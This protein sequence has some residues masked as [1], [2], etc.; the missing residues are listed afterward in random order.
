[1]S[2]ADLDR[3]IATVRQLPE[4]AERAAPDVADVIE[5]ELMRTTTAGQSPNGTPWQ[6]TLEGGKPLTGAAKAIGVA[7]VGRTIYVRLTGVEARHHLG[8]ARGG[9]ERQ[10]IPTGRLPPR[11]ADAVREVLGRHFAELASGADHG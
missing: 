7:A 3:M 9:I 8:R 4:L 10:V 5:R 11:M 1:M 6:L 2:L